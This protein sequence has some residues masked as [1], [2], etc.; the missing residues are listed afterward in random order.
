MYIAPWILR[1]LITFVLCVLFWILDNFAKKHPTTSIILA[2][3]IGT[4]SYSIWQT[5]P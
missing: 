2:Y 4:I 5:I 1:L 3:L